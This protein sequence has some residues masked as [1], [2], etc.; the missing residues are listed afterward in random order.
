MSRISA[1]DVYVTIDLIDII[2][3]GA[4]VESTN[5]SWTV[6]GET[7]YQTDIGYKWTGV[8]SSYV[9]LV[10]ADYSATESD[11]SYVSNEDENFYPHT[12]TQGGIEY[13]Y[14]GKIFDVAVKAEPFN[15]K[16]INITSAS[17]S[18]RTYSID[19]PCSRYML[20]AGDEA[21]G[22]KTKFGSWLLV[23]NQKIYGAVKKY[24]FTLFQHL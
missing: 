2:S 20:W 11:F 13:Q 3:N 15:I 22:D 14:L 4:S 10:V 19:I 24:N 6:S 18:D 9:Q 17:W 16:T 23:D 8:D 5:F 7:S 12:G 1:S 21:K